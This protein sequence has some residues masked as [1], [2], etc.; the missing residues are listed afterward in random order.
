MTQIDD[1]DQVFSALVRDRATGS[2]DNPGL[3]AALHKAGFGL[4]TDTTGAFDQILASHRD[5]M[6]LASLIAG[7]AHAADPSRAL[8]NAARLLSEPDRPPCP[9]NPH[10]LGLFLG[11]S[12]HMAD[13]LMARPTLLSFLGRPFDS[14]TAPLRYQQ[15]G[16]SDDADRQLRLAQQEDLLAIAWA[17]LVERLDVEQVTGLLSRLADA[18]VAG[19]C[20][21][22]ETDRYFAIVALGKL[23]G[24]ELNYS[25]DIDLMFVRPDG[26]T[27]QVSADDTARRLIRRIGKQTTEGHLYRVDM[28]LRPEGGTG[29][30]TR[31][32]ESSLQY[33]RTLGRP[34]ERQML[35]KARV[36]FDAEGAGSTFLAA[37]REWILQCGMDA[38][39][40]QQFKRLKAATEAHYA[41][42]ED[43]T[44]IKQ[45]PGGIRDIETIVQFLALQHAAKQPS[46]LTTSTLNGLE[47]LR[48]AGALNSIEAARL[49]SAYRFHRKVENLLQ[50][51][52][53]IQTHSLP[54]DRTTLASLTAH[55]NSEQFD[56][57]LSQHRQQVREIF[58]RHFTH[59]FAALD[60]PSAPAATLSEWILNGALENDPAVTTKVEH[61]LQNLGFLH[62]QTSRIALQRAASPVSRFLPASPR[63]LSTCASIAPPLLD[64]IVLA[65]DPDTTLDRFERMTRGVG[66]REVLYAQFVDEPRLLEILTDLASGSP[67]LAD[68]LVTEPHVFDDFIDALLTGFRG[69]ARRRRDLADM[70]APENGDP[71]LILSDH[72]KLELL[73]IGVSDLQDRTTTRETLAQI[74]QLCVDIL[75]CAYDLVFTSAVETMGQPETVRG[76]SQRLPA[77]MAVLAFGKLGGMEVNYASD[78]DLIFVY[79][80]DGNTT[81]GVTNAQFFTKVAEEFIA[82]LTGSRGG[83]RLYRID[84]RLRPEGTKGPLVTSLKAFT[85]YYASSRAAVIESQALLKGRAVAGDATLG[86]EVFSLI[87]DHLRGLELP[88]DYLAQVRDIRDKIEAKA[89]GFDLKRGSGG[90]IDIEHI[91]QCLQL[92]H[93]R[94]HHS[95]LVQ[96]TPRALEVLASEG[97]LNDVDATW[98]R[99]TYLWLRRVE[100]RIQIAM[101]VD[102]KTLPEDPS[103]LR[104]LALRLGYPDTGEGDAGHLLRSELE[105]VAIQTRAH[106]DEILAPH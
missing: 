65:P 82:Q 79:S 39:A 75:R 88:E 1:K 12:Q 101:G 72:Q 105:S 7:C 83:P 27:D 77:N 21:G 47:K 10:H 59:A 86:R 13:L 52:H 31:S 89:T 85:R 28:R 48:I 19:A 4:E 32:L 36:I 20:T 37:T 93:C 46:L 35:T 63:L 30:L 102:S 17:D 16:S 29:P 97:L 84:T 100:M 45:A 71:W 41:S 25:S 24:V 34:W 64:R 11:A 2:L 96:E 58:D 49:R 22:L 44:D 80:A 94:Q 6:E 103:A 60:S 92:L 70:A 9:V 26:V 76:L 74:S 67:S 62:P 51:M 33:Y 81:E 104:N 90:M 50:V 55:E 61:A 3:Q 98:L 68:I 66:A 69:T 8:S 99:E 18:V 54:A 15:I 78:A 57:A 38:G 91:V 87:R 5:D 95:V 106:F 23:G 43:R 56:Q 73:R 14:L 53:R 40:I 42:P